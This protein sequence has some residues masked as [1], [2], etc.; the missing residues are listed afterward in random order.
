MLAVTVTLRS[1]QLL[2][3]SCDFDALIRR[4]EQESE[5]NVGAILAFLGDAGK[6]LNDEEENC[7]CRTF[8]VVSAEAGT[9]AQTVQCLTCDREFHVVD[10]HL[11]EAE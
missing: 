5:M 4:H 1:F 10:N 8:R 11:K 7:P 6:H 3:V 9:G 2:I